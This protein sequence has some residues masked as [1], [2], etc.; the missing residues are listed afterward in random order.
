MFSPVSLILGWIFSIGIAMMGMGQAPYSGLY[1][2]WGLCITVEKFGGGVGNMMEEN[3]WMC[4]DNLM[5][6]IFAFTQN[7]NE[8]LILEPC[9]CHWFLV[10]CSKI[11]FTC[12]QF[13]AKSI[14][15]PLKVW[16]NLFELANYHQFLKFL[17]IFFCCIY[18]SCIWLDRDY[19]PWRNCANLMVWKMSGIVNLFYFENTFC[20]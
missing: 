1:R 19:C 2:L 6:C 17:T 10:H 11:D 12:C 5:T 16:L 4:E 14:I 3:A 20:L 18:F 9:L 15:Y 13:S 7:F 8:L